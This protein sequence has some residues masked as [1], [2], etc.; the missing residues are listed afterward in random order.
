MTHDHDINKRTVTDP[1]SQII[2]IDNPQLLT[3][4]YLTNCQFW[5]MRLKNQTS[6]N[7]K[8]DILPIFLLN[9]LVVKV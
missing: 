7:I 3:Y 8:L 4:M 9:K 1:P 2:Q 6:L 5:Y